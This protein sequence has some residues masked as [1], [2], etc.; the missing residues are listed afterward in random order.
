LFFAFKKKKSEQT[1]FAKT[2]KTDV[3]DKDAGSDAK[4][5]VVEEIKE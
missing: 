1:M 5:L 3:A 4:L 2:T